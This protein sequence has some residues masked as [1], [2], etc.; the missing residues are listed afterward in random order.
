MMTTNSDVIEK[1]AMPKATVAV[2][3]EAGKKKITKKELR[4]L[5][6]RSCQLD[7]SWDYERQ[8]HIAYSYGMT[9]VIR[10][11]YSG[12]E[13]KEKRIAALKRGL[14]FMACT[15]HLSTM[16]FGINAAMEEEN[17]TNPN[18][19][20][21][22]INAVKTSLM[23]P[24]AGI[25]DSLIPGTL[26]IIAAGI[27]ISFAASGSILGP[28]LYLLVF[29]IPAFIIRYFG[30]KYGY[31][32]GSSFIEKIA[33]SG[34]MGKVSYYAGII[35]LMVI[36]GMICQQIWLDITL[37][38]G[39]GDFAQP[40]TSYLDQIMPCLVQLG[41]FGIMYWLIGKKV[42]TT[43]ILLALVVICCAVSF[44]FGL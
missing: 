28:L 43:T 21:N 24:L 37:K 5:F 17:A 20:G 18:F 9:P 34:I 8:Q 16:L 10:K 11:L 33:K 31:G 1:K 22:S 19:D 6:W 41:L 4:Q 35:G 14:E 38:V 13:N 25:G 30:L 29:N 26:R 15:P 40:L 2:S 7:I 42:K 32:M 36:G 23:G 12:E 39:S 44:I 27:A 3:G